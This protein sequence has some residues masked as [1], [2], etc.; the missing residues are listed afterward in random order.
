MHGVLV[1]NVAMLY[2]A[3]IKFEAK[4]LEEFCFRFAMNHLTAVV[5]TDA[6]HKLE[7]S[8]VKSFITKAA[9]Y[10]AFKY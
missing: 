6:F 10:G 2:A 4:D 3:A 8:A 5:Q 1:E 9:V 7:E